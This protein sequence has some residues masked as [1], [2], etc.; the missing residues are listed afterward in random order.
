MAYILILNLFS[1]FFLCGL[2]WTVQLVHYPLFSFLD[3]E[4]FT[5]ASA[6]HRQKISYIV[7]PVMLTELFT[8]IW[9]SLFSTSHMFI[10]ISGLIAVLLI[11]SITF[12]LQVPL[13]AYLSDHYDKKLIQ[14]LV[15]SNWWRTLLWSVKS[16][17]GIWLLS[18]YLI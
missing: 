6:F 11:W 9:L 2:I 5:E 1:S 17:L 18:Q 10:H 8:S 3:P 12:L 16:G 4:R 7:V 13:H 14:R 15:R